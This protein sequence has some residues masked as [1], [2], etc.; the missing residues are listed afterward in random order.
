MVTAGSVFLPTQRGAP[1]ALMEGEAAPDGD[2]AVEEEWSHAVPVGV[3]HRGQPSEEVR[4]VLG[5]RARAFQTNNAPTKLDLDPMRFSADDA[6]DAAAVHLNKERRCCG[7]R[8]CCVQDTFAARLWSR[9]KLDH[10][11]AD[12]SPGFILLKSWL[13][14]IVSLLLDKATRNPDSVTTVFVGILGL[15]SYIY[16]GVMLAKQT[17]SAGLLGAVIGTLVAAACYLPPSQDPSRWMLLVSVPFSVVTT[18]YI[19]MFLGVEHPAGFT[20]GIFSALFVVIV[21]FAYPPIAD[22]V[23][24]DDPRRVIWQTLLVRVI[25]LFTGVASAYVVNFVVSATAPLAI[26]RMT[27][28]FAER[29][30]W[31]TQKHRLDP[32]DQRV[33][34]NYG[35]VVA[36]IKQG[37]MVEEAAQSWVFSERTRIQIERIRKRAKTMFRF[38][39]FRTFLELYV[40][41]LDVRDAERDDVIRLIEFSTRNAAGGPR[42]GD[43][44]EA[45][46]EELETFPAHLHMEK[47]VL[48]SI[49][50]DLRDTTITYRPD[51]EIMPFWGII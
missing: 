24:V 23:P 1:P 27:M 33:Q 34:A 47:S 17:L 4:A 14:I 22:L 25:A 15:A 5:D 50:C 42:S 37:T 26:F 20:A 6:M 45:E 11:A 19:M 41:S 3:P 51:D 49:L 12:N 31:K 21:P 48:K 18:Q 44:L 46:L 29:M 2:P 32:L 36:Q 40:E 43:T 13:V 30:L 39:S 16:L 28:F 8:R 10:V 38:L 9:L 7:G 35:K